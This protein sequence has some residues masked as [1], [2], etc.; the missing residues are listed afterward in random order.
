MSE[1][2]QEYAR[3]LAHDLKAPLSAL[4][5]LVDMVKEEDQKELLKASIERYETLISDIEKHYK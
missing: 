1:I 2:S 3:K 4:K 5:V